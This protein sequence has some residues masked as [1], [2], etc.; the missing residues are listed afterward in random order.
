MTTIYTEQEGCDS[1]RA[2]AKHDFH[3]IFD[4]DTIQGY[5][6]KSI[7]NTPYCKDA[8]ALTEDNFMTKYILNSEKKIDATY[9]ESV[10]EWAQDIKADETFQKSVT[11]RYKIYKINRAQH[12]SSKTQ[13]FIQLS[14]QDAGIEDDVFFICDVAYAN[15]REDLTYTA[16]KPAKQ[17]MRWVQNAQTLYD[18]A[19]KTAWH[20]GSDYGFKSNDS[21]FVFSWE[22]ANL[23]T[24]TYYP[25]WPGGEY[26][27]TESF[28]ETMLYTN[29]NMYMGIRAD[30]NDTDDYKKQDSVLVITD[31][32]KPGYY[33]F[34]DKDLSS[35]GDGILNKSQM[36]SYR[37]KG[38]DLRNFVKFL[39]TETGETVGQRK[40]LLDEVLDY[41]SEIQ[42]LAKKVGD[43]SQSLSCCK[44]VMH[45]QE[46]QDNAAGFKG[47]VRNF[48]SNGNHAFVSYDR[49]AIGCALNYNCP[50]VLQ[51]TQE[52]FVLYVRED[53]VSQEK[54]FDKF[55]ALFGEMKTDIK[56]DLFGKEK[57]ELLKNVGKKLAELP[58]KKIE[59]DS[60]YK[61]YLV[62][63]LL[64]LP[65]LQML[66][67]IGSFFE[68][69]EANLKMRILTSIQE[70]N[71]KLIKENNISINES[72]LEKIVETVLVK[73]QKSM[74]TQ[75]E[76]TK[77]DKSYKANN[78]Q[79]KNLYGLYA[80]ILSIK[81]D[82]DN[83][84][85]TME[86]I[87]ALLS[88]IPLVSIDFKERLKLLAK[89]HRDNITSCVPFHYSETVM[90][91]PKNADGFIDRATQCF[92][93]TTIILPIF[94]VL[95]K[96]SI[97]NFKTGFLNMIIGALD[98]TKQKAANIQNF[99]FETTNLMALEQLVRN[100][101]VEKESDILDKLEKAKGEET[102]AI[103][104]VNNDIDVILD[105]LD[106]TITGA[107]I[108]EQNKKIQEENEKI[109]KKNQEIDSE[110]EKLKEGNRK[111]LEEI[112]ENTKKRKIVEEPETNDKK[113][114][115]EEND[116]KRKIEE[117]VKKRK[118][119]ENDK[120]RKIEEND[121]NIKNLPKTKKTK[122][123]EKIEF[124]MKLPRMD[125]NETLVDYLK[126]MKLLIPKQM[127]KHDASSY[128][129]AF[130]NKNTKSHIQIQIDM[131]LSMKTEPKDSLSLSTRSKKTIIEV[132]IKKAFEIE[133]FLKGLFGIF[134]FM[135]MSENN[136]IGLPIIF[137]N[138]TNQI[139]LMKYFLEIVEVVLFPEEGTDEEENI[140]MNNDTLVSVI[141]DRINKKMKI[142]VSP[143]D[144]TKM[145]ED[146]GKIE[147]DTRSRNPEIKLLLDKFKFVQ[148]HLGQFTKNRPLNFSTENTD[149]FVSNKAFQ[150][151]AQKYVDAFED[152]IDDLNNGF[153]S[154]NSFRTIIES[155]TLSF[156]S[157]ELAG[158]FSGLNANQ[159]NYNMALLYHIEN[160]LSKKR[161]SESGKSEDAPPLYD[162]DSFMGKLLSQLFPGGKHIGGGGA[163]D[164]MIDQI[165]G[166]FGADIKSESPIFNK[167]IALNI[168][169]ILQFYLTGFNNDALQAL[170][171]DKSKQGILAEQIATIPSTT[172]SHL[173]SHERSFGLETHPKKSIKVGG[174]KTK[175]KRAVS[176]KKGAYNPRRTKKRKNKTRRNWR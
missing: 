156:G 59:N 90:R 113:R 143:L 64:L 35:K 83:V 50:I 137:G 81:Y 76:S 66:N 107:N 69:T 114:K 61:S 98:A 36:T 84:K 53:L 119:E 95:N 112:A 136:G 167:E 15:V 158:D 54:Q 135:R 94:D 161:L 147:K 121:K 164:H 60:E 75:I 118:I 5:V 41:S 102:K 6:T 110:I 26:N 126:E 106:I 57:E 170:N 85:T 109:V 124:P 115:I 52:G 139:S 134:T 33:A 120:K 123:P 1:S 40:I 171:G 4:K 47:G 29:K 14:L 38:N 101:F 28:P 32:K 87:T 173:S 49:I 72:S 30:K 152:Y 48:D 2:D 165:L 37:A 65:V 80:G 140:E 16:K 151:Y 138:K 154:I 99:S 169:N 19:G 31:P 77:R 116:K 133:L 111:M 100:G 74:E 45:F 128:I 97:V 96:L 149:A 58:T 20:T 42:I 7:P 13:S 43:A 44:P 117:N 163:R 78:P 89:G 86:N 55:E 56:L 63:H 103:S 70:A 25:I 160:E 24:M 176:K 91:D 148:V 172:L 9:I 141:R 105:E 92:G 122:I 62:Q 159:F 34:A 155:N 166:I 168:K 39:K 142:K 104:E 146:Y 71:K 68:M 67:T 3:T 145:V 131:F 157:R 162:E 129:G 27:F 88:T 79:L 125:Q 11:D 150:Y 132:E 73:I 175:Q 130:L 22:N 93:T 18:P 144:V 10:S 174:R 23:K 21:N 127:I 8:N 82:L 17:K 51:N 12:D 108:L 46:F 153:F